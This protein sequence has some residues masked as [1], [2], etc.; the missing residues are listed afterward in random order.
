MI[1]LSIIIV[2]LQLAASFVIPLLAAATKLFAGEAK[3][4][5]T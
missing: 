3:S 2:I 1:T 5:Q 4:D